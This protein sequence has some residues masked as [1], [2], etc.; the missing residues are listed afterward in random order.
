[1]GKVW[2]PELCTLPEVASVRAVK[3]WSGDDV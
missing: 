3:M 2:W 1:V